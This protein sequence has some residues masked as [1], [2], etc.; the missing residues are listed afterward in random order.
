MLWDYLK[1][2]QAQPNLILENHEIKE[3]QELKRH[4]INK[5]LKHLHVLIVREKF[6]FFWNS[7]VN[8]NTSNFSL[9]DCSHRSLFFL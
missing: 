9:F 5:Q 3:I 6:Q 7:K 1:T 2:F 8:L 4:H